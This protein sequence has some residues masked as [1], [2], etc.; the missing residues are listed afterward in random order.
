MTCRRMVGPPKKVQGGNGY[1]LQHTFNSAML[2]SLQALRQGASADKLQ[3][4]A[5]KSHP[6][7]DSQDP[8]HCG[9]N[10][11][12]LHGPPPAGSS[13]LSYSDNTRQVR[14]AH[15]RCARSMR[16]STRNQNCVRPA[17]NN[18]E[19]L[20]ELQLQLRSGIECGR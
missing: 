1:T 10:A 3:V 2:I 7:M 6:L 19:S 4:Q 15:S 8:L 12:Y 18:A 11:Q 17:W 16:E 13:H 20:Q 9:H 5:A 14:Q